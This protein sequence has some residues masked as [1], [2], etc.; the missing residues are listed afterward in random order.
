MKPR[1]TTE[2]REKKQKKKGKLYHFEFKTH[3]HKLLK[4]PF[5][6]L[7][8]VSLHRSIVQRF[9]EIIHADLSIRGLSPEKPLAPLIPFCECRSK[10]K[11]RGWLRLQNP[12]N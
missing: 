4:K 3:F 11:E 10:G 2:K 8:I 1:K 12:I 9:L 5:L 6:H 7:T